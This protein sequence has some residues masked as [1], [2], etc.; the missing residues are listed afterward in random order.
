MNLHIKSSARPL[1]NAAVQIIGILS[2]I[3]GICTM[4]FS[5]IGYF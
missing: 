1:S 5:T 2:V 3:T 4:I